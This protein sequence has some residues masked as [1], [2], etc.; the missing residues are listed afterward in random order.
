MLNSFWW[1]H[2]RQNAK[3]INW[4]SW[5]RLSIPK[6]DGGLGFKNLR[7]FNNAMLGKQAWKFMTEPDNMVTRLFKARYF[8]KCDFM[9]S[10]CGHNPS[11]V[12]RSIW[13]TKNIVK[14]GYKWSIGTGHHIPVWN[15]TWLTDGSSVETPEWLPEELKNITVADVMHAPLRVWNVGVI[16]NLVSVEDTTL[17]LQTPLFESVHNDRR[18]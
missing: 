2:N 11:Y 15:Q 4:M 8:P 10:R 14:A 6:K 18:I 16:R 3:G 17:I 5:K 13:E 1:G 7:A 12:W 9:D